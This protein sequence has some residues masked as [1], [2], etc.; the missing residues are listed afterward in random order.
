M[1]SLPIEAKE[2]AET[3]PTYPKPKMLTHKP[4]GILL[5]IEY[6]TAFES[7]Y[8]TPKGVIYFEE[9]MASLSG[10]LIRNPRRSAAC[11]GTTLLAL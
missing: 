5:V 1:T 3:E 11:L 6:L 7:L 2:A 8:R 10:A 9:L 4:K